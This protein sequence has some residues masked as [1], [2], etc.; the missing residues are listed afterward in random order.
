MGAIMKMEQ[1]E[2]RGDDQKQSDDTNN[3]SYQYDKSISTYSSRNQTSLF[4]FDPNSLN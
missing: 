3:Y 4:Y 1:K 2:S